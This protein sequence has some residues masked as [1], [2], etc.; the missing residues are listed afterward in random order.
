MERYT[1][2]NEK[3][4][5]AVAKKFAATLKGGEVIG[6]TGDLGAGK[7]AFTKGLAAGLGIKN[8]ITSPTFV[9]MKNY[10]S[11]NSKKTIQQLAHIDA[12][13]LGSGTDLQALGVSD[14]FDNPTCVTVIEW[15]ER[16]HEILPPHHYCISITIQDATTRHITIS[17]V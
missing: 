1:T 14:Y 13:R 9:L 2:H 17:H 12:Y 16:I 4:T 8:I 6:M 10:Q 7:T 11:T 5:F 3:E 15:A